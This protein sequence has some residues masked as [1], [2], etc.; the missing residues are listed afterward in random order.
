MYNNIVTAAFK[1][2]FSQSELFFSSSIISSINLIFRGMFY[3]GVTVMGIY[4][5]L[6][7]VWVFNPSNHYDL[8]AM[9]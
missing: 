7:L 4:M 2:L 5:F 6:I 3:L 8:T 9:T 1:E